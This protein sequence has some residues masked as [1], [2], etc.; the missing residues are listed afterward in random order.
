MLLQTDKVGYT[1]ASGEFEEYEIYTFKNKFINY[2]ADQ[3]KLKH[4]FE[5]ARES[6]DKNAIRSALQA[7]W[8]FEEKY[9][10]RKYKQEYYD[11]QKIWKQSNVV[12]DPISGIDVT[13]SAQVSA[14]AFL[15]GTFQGAFTAALLKTAGTRRER[16]AMLTTILK[17]VGFPQE[18]Q[19]TCAE[20]QLDQP[21]F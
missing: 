15:D 13:A 20:S 10:H 11:L 14:D 18:P 8:D 5:K 3:A 9:M 21:L 17:Q 12:R 1:N 4:D 7:I 16:F 2:R 19:L 6:G